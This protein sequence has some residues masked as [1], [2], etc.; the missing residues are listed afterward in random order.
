MPFY[1]RHEKDNGMDREVE[2]EFFMRF[3]WYF[4]YYTDITLLKNQFKRVIIY[5]V[6]EKYIKHFFNVNTRNIL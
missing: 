4:K 6:T 5:K 3:N 1:L 2:G